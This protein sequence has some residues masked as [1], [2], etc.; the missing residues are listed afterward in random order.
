M[1]LTRLWR[2]RGTCRQ[3][4]PEQPARSGIDGNGALYIA[5]AGN[6]RIRKI[7]RGGVIT[8]VAGNG[9]AGF[10]GDGGPAISASLNFPEGL[11]LDSS[12]NLYIA[13]RFNQ[14]A[15]KVTPTGIITTVAGNGSFGYSG[16][17]GPAASASFTELQGLA[18]DINGNLYV[19]DSYN[20]RLR[21]VSL[22]SI[23]STV[24]VEAPSS[25]R[26]MA[27]L[28]PTPFSTHLLAW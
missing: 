19:A 4:L 12:G 18:V 5:D 24:P 3:R 25:P 17:D 1:A 15:R 26:R 7:P 6:N 13:D 28:P 11:A 22:G 8:T 16:D 21:K 27:S 2:R 20:G 9:T 14:R 23:V 10:L